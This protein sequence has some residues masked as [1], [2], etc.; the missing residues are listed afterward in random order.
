MKTQLLTVAG[1][2]ACLILIAVDADAQIKASERGAVVQTID[3]T[4]IAIDYG[5]PSLRGRSEPFGSTVPWGKVWTPGANWA[6]TIETD[7][8]ITVNGHSLETG[9]YSIWMEVQ[10]EEWTLIFDPQPRRFHLMAP[11]PSEDQLRFAISPGSGEHT[12]LLTWSFPDVH[13]TG[14][15]LQMAWDETTV[16]LDIGVTTTQQVTVASDFASRFVGSYT[17]TTTGPL[18][19]GTVGFEVSHDSEGHLVAQWENPP[20]PRLG[21]F[22]LSPL[23]AGMFIPVELED[24]EIYGMVTDL[25]FEFGPMDGEAESFELRAMDD[26]LW[27]RAAR[28]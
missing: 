3:G 4:T 24:G 19:D 8:D 13:A 5:R 1:I 21:T 25:V 27:G 7:R 16:T 10:P 22:W 28:R 6:T 15:T 20:V 12:E 9:T 18:G 17:F 26:A 2:V 23:G 11:P 14:G